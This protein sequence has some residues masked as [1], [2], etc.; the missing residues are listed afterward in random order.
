[1]LPDTFEQSIWSA[2]SR[3]GPALPVLEGDMAAD[4]AIVGAGFLGLSTALHLAELG[5]RTVLLEADVPGFGAS[6]RNTG[7]VVPSLKTALG[8]ADVGASLGE[9]FGERLVDL[10]GMS[11]DIVF[12]L[13]R[14]VGI[15]CDAEQS[16]WMQPAH[17]AAIA[18][19]LERRVAEWQRRGRGVEMLD[20]AEVA[21][22]TGS[23]RFHGA[24][25][26][27]S[28]G[29]LNPLAYARGLA[30]ACLD[31][32]VSLFAESPVSNIARRDG[33]WL[34]SSRKGRVEASRVFL[35]TNALTGRLAPE[36][37]RSIIPTRVFQ[38]ASQRF[39]PEEQA[40]ILPT[41]SP[42]ADTRRHT[43]AVRWSPDGR[44]LTG[45]LVLPGPNRLNRAEAVF[46][47]R[48]EEFFPAAGNMIAEHVW[49]GVIAA[50]LDALPRFLSL[51][52]GLDAAIG[53]N[54]R[55]VA[56]TT[57]LGREIAGLLAGRVTAG[58]FVL[59]HVRPKAVPM[60]TFAE[61]APY[62]WLGWSEFRDRRDLR[63][64]D[65]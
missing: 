37:D 43:F 56:L 34:L 20:G 22:R 29:Q 27:P 24:L 1:M 3:P 23:T 51:A 57:S 11:G 65:T 31:A 58:E 13:I 53:C 41:R 2:L 45:G 54:G 6:G 36:L 16:G 18:S 55:G 62:V 19:V 46:T 61:A 64:A 9:V 47:R 52:P 28:G 5:V 38:I 42:I 32:G 39:G 17:T 59:P 8:P 49:T 15:E 26:V 48:L 30:G 60:R 40:R 33:K 14:R 21:R 50:T 7:F 44:L 25:F 35:A 63:A 4:V 10:V 12:D